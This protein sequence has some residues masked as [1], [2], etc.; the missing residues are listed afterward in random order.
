MKRSFG[1]TIQ[2]RD[3]MLQQKNRLESDMFLAKQLSDAP[4]RYCGWTSDSSVVVAC[5]YSHTEVL[6][7]DDGELLR[8][9]PQ[10]FP[11]ISR[12]VALQPEFARIASLDD[13]GAIHIREIESGRDVMLQTSKVARY[14]QR[15]LCYSP[16]G[17]WLAVSSNEGVIDL[18]QV[19]KLEAELRWQKLLPRASRVI[20]SPESRYL[21]GGND[22]KKMRAW[23]VVN[24]DPVPAIEAIL[25]GLI[26]F[27][28]DG[29]QLVTVD[30]EQ[31][32]LLL[33]FWQ[34]PDRKLIL[35]TRSRHKIIEQ[36]REELIYSPGGHI[37]ALLT[38][39]HV[40]FWDAVSGAE[41]GYITGFSGAPERGACAFTPD[42][43]RFILG[44]SVGI[45]RIWD[46]WSG[47]LTALLGGH[48]QKISSIS[49]SPD[50]SQ[51]TSAD[52][53]GSL[54]IWR[55]SRC[56]GVYGVQG[57]TAAISALTMDPA[58]EFAATGDYDGHAF[59]WNLQK[60]SEF[61]CEKLEWDVI[62]ELLFRPD[63]K[64]LAVMG[65]ATFKVL[66]EDKT[67][68]SYAS[69][70]NSALNELTAMAFS[71]D[72]RYLAVGMNRTSVEVQCWDD[73]SF[74]IT[75]KL[76]GLPCVEKM[77]VAPDASHFIVLSNSGKLEMRD[78]SGK[79]REI[80]PSVSPGN[81]IRQGCAC[82]KGKWIAWLQDHHLVIW[83][84]EK[85]R[86]IRRNLDYDEAKSFIQ[87]RPDGRQ[88]A[89]WSP[90]GRIMLWAADRGQCVGRLAGGGPITALTY[91]GS[92][93]NMAIGRPDGMVAM[94]TDCLPSL[95]RKGAPGYPRTPDLII[96]SQNE[97]QDT[98]FG[99]AIVQ[100][101]FAAK[102]RY[103]LAL[104]L[105]GRLR[106]WNCVEKN[107]QT[108]PDGFPSEEISRFAVDGSWLLVATGCRLFAA[109]LDSC[110]SA[111][112]L[113]V[114]A[115]RI[116]LVKLNSASNSAITADAREIRRWSLISGSLTDSM[117]FQGCEE[118]IS[119]PDMRHMAAIHKM[120]ESV[121]A[122]WETEPYRLVR[123]T[124]IPDPKLLTKMVFTED[125]HS[126]QLI[127]SESAREAWDLTKNE[128]YPLG[129]ASRVEL[130]ANSPWALEIE[131]TLAI[132]RWRWNSGELV[133]QTFLP[134][135]QAKDWRGKDSL[136]K[137]LSRAVIYERGKWQA[138]LWDI[139]DQKKISVLKHAAAI[140]V[141]CFT[142]NEEWLVT[143]DEEGN[144]K[145]WN[146]ETGALLKMMD[147][148][149]WGGSEF[150]IQRI[151]LAPDSRYLATG[152]RNGGLYL[153]KMKDGMLLHDLDG[154]MES[155]SDI[156]FSPD[157]TH[158]LS[159]DVAGIY[160]LWNVDDG[161][162]I[163][164]LCPDTRKRGRVLSA[165]EWMPDHM[166]LRFAD[167][168]GVVRTMALVDGQVIHEFKTDFWRPLSLCSRPGQANLLALT[169]AT[170][171]VGLWQ[172]DK[173]ESVFSCRAMEGGTQTTFSRFG[174]WLATGDSLGHVLVMDGGTGKEIARMKVS[175]TVRHID[176]S[177]WNDEWVTVVADSVK[178]S[179]FSLK[180]NTVHHVLE[181]SGAM[182]LQ[183]A[184]SRDGR[185]VAASYASQ[186]AVLW[187]V[188]T[189]EKGPLPDRGQID[190]F[191]FSASGQ[192]LIIEYRNGRSLVWNTLQQQIVELQMPDAHHA[193]RLFFLGESARLIGRI[194]RWTHFWDA[195]TG[196]K[197]CSLVGEVRQPEWVSPNGM[198]IL[199]FSEASQ[200]FRVVEA[201]NMSERSSCAAAGIHVHVTWSEDSRTVCL[202]HD[203]R[204]PKCL[205]I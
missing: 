8:S 163:A 88:L 66:S 108:L 97:V 15:E 35:E 77:V 143:A 204:S 142:T 70:Q 152:Q 185:W 124:C 174:H 158:M 182:P 106:L 12:C 75:S 118:I 3:R 25:T 69:D 199:V 90:S 102:D 125:G 140:T 104:D 109:D 117:E 157:G 34:W 52:T 94:W 130:R 41:L 98:N 14:Y 175:S 99:K 134:F 55:L 155:V 68:F 51:F 105:S 19:D 4:L 171:T 183:Y 84:C 205:K 133:Q 48:S 71:Q 101:A 65:N 178:L 166:Q 43:T 82:P 202:G 200:E 46:C 10:G 39:S 116:Q 78:R 172:T 85:E 47:E 22:Q 136:S 179:L 63:H 56:E 139:S 126:L 127:Y 57:H 61:K 31:S 120:T 186:R 33:R 80:L 121:L 11:S 2:I 62:R 83:I 167:E 16:D 89:I 1:K 160:K 92:G 5:S 23:R 176:G 26:G 129:P 59:L 131:T 170:G 141:A 196:G 150:G 198:F 169:G 79:S 191:E 132:F 123:E 156:E 91:S 147:C 81:S 73:P 13:S 164:E 190:R 100:L 165:R 197:L 32:G 113:G 36:C 95:H 18:W 60:L 21:I 173:A 58:G 28:P 122:L 145:I 29:G 162:E 153:W 96:F 86:I 44:D 187:N 177:E 159:G 87:V 72:S 115:D 50:G 195:A 203:N 114:H 6:A 137:D 181:E 76:K 24:G 112:A 27:R 144:I 103:L 38:A 37:L 180:N 42:G 110:A 192:Y 201:E 45:I 149:G 17:R 93:R 74:E 193:D 53:C 30:R 138:E 151:A 188:Q 194:Q 189:K 135:Y 64:Q 20:F 146:T 161:L 168:F 154:H 9:W 67:L 119:T 111:I 7:A 54:K 49:I 107:E 184:I 148:R 128:I 40:M